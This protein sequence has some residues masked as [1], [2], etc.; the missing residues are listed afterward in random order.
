MVE[1][2]NCEECGK[3]LSTIASLLRHK[4]IVHRNSPAE[5]LP[6]KWVK[7]GQMFESVASLKRH[8]REQHFNIKLNTDFQEALETPDSFQCEMCDNK[9]KRAENLRRHFKSMHTENKLSCSECGKIFGRK[10]NLA[11]HMKTKH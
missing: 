9:F 4:T 5:K 10:D 2:F 6:C 11:R 3:K 7:C 8:M 1:V